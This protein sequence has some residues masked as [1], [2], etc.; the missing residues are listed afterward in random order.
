VPTT[1]PTTVADDDAPTPR[2]NVLL[3]DATVTQG[4]T[5]V[6]GA[7]W[8]VGH[9]LWYAPFGDGDEILWGL[10]KPVDRDQLDDSL[11]APFTIAVVKELRKGDATGRPLWETEVD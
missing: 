3:V 11:G 4:E 5:W 1:V 2:T 6:A 8:L 9:V 7:F 10:A